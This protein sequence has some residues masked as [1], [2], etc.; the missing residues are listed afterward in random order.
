M[1][2]GATTVRTVRE[3]RMEGGEETFENVFTPFSSLPCVINFVNGL[4]LLALVRACIPAGDAAILAA[5]VQ[6][7]ALDHDLSRW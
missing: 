6:P 4:V 7:L 1:A 3:N 2:T 5:N